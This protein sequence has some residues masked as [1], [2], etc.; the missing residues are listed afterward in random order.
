MINKILITFFLFLISLLLLISLTSA[1][2][3]GVSPSAINFNGYIN[4][5]ICNKIILFS[6]NE[7]ILID[8]KWSLNKELIK[9]INEYNNIAEDLG[10][11]IQYPNK[12]RVEAKQ[13]I[14]VCLTAK[15]I[16]KYYGLLNIRTENR[17]AGIGIW[18]SVLVGNNPS[19]NS[20]K[21]TGNVIDDKTIN[22]DKIKMALSISSM[23]WMIVL[24]FLI[25]VKKRR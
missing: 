7:T 4:E 21:L 5:K 1:V 3:L 17:P 24:I 20:N 12:I 14:E 25:V 15:N 13:E 16:G 9:N 19:I 23:T 10:I 18:M 22:Q 11:K 6:S 8:D 2:K